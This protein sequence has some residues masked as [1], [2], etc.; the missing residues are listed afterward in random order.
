MVRKIPY[1]F[2][3]ELFSS[4]LDRIASDNCFD[5]VE[6]FMN[7]R[8]IEIMPSGWR[9]GTYTRIDC[10][11]P[12]AFQGF[13][14]PDGNIIMAHTTL[15][16]YIPFWS[17]GL[18]SRYVRQCSSVRHGK[19]ILSRRPDSLVDVVR[20]CPECNRV[21]TYVH[22]EHN[23]PGVSV[24][25]KHACPLSEKM[26]DQY[27]HILEKEVRPGPHA[28]KIA[29]FVKAFIDAD[30]RFCLQD[31]FPVFK[32]KVK[33]WE[34]EN[35][36]DFISHLKSLGFTAAAAGVKYSLR[37]VESCDNE[38]PFEEM[39]IAL[40]VLYEGDVA[41]LASEVKTT[42]SEEQFLK[43]IKGRFKLDSPYDERAVC[44]TCM[45]CGTQFHTSVH[46]ILSGWGC[47]HEDGLLSDDDMFK[48]LFDHVND[49][50]ELL[51]FF[52][53]FQNPITV[54][55]LATG[56]MLRVKP[57]RFLNFAHE[58]LIEKKTRD[59]EDIRM[60][61]KSYG[62]VLESVR[63]G[64]NGMI[65]MNLLDPV[66]GGRFSE[67][68]RTF[69]RNQACKCCAVVQPE[70]GLDDAESHT[71]DERAEDTARIRAAIAGFD[72]IF[73]LD[74]LHITDKR[75]TAN[76]VS[77]MARDGELRRVDSG[78]YCN[79]SVFPSFMDVVDAKYVVRHGERRGF[80]CGNTFL[81]DLGLAI[82]APIPTVVS[83]MSDK[84]FNTQN[85]KVCR[86]SIRVIK[87]HVRVT[88]DNW[89]AL[90]VLFML[91]HLNESDALDKVVMYEVV[92]RWMKFE[93][94]GF[95]D[96]VPYRDDFSA[97]VFNDAV[98]LLR[99]TT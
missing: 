53:D 69:R 42:S 34:S 37:Y 17:R 46:S 89:K 47:P 81:K 40:M 25:W 23:I 54:R 22:R 68:L 75:F 27:G 7:A 66:C 93:N 28:L 76:L 13:S 97:R 62:L 74:D 98:E 77:R 88:A 72:G 4:Y 99:R 19:G 6:E 85:L 63:R 73:F 32:D 1:I 38:V 8:G 56:K 36:K 16:A 59:I 64:K 43:A 55:H 82:D 10:F 21:A 94:I 48:R 11:F 65:M 29:R 12:G 95:A 96:I 92:S 60:E 44:L 80:H 49:G 33:T 57:D 41:T 83:M 67:T 58:G 35:K 45:K 9:H 61:V 31:L 71:R 5:N 18:A 79:P 84:A 90:A 87:S 86:R 20:I 39:M 51:D 26:N 24:C 52:R 78:A 15:P 70:L 50:Y 3:G 14:V 91:R 30:L 2:E